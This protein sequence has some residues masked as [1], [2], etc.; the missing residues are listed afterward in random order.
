MDGGHNASRGL[1]AG[2][3]AAP[4]TD[5]LDG[6]FVVVP[7]YNEA[8]VIH[9]VV[10]ALCETFPNVIVVNDGSADSTLAVLAT[11]PVTVISH[12]I[13]LGQGA[14]L[15]TGITYALSRGAQYIITFDGD[16]Q[17][18]VED[19]I[20]ALRE[21]RTGRCDA[22]CGS[23]FL[24][25]ATN[26]P[27]LRKYLLKAAVRFSN[28]ATKTQLTDAHNG[29]RAFSRKAASAI[30]ITQDGMAH[31]SEITATLARK[32]LVIHE[33]PVEVRYTQYSRAKGQ[34]SLNSVNI[35]VEL[36]IERFLR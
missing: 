5:S 23:R 14:A 15:Q 12:A 9:S 8:A 19:A 7:A 11:A 34:S 35:L 17:H 20:A 32:G 25:A 24:G 36:I 30:D 26:I 18:R 4:D 31:A 27:R 33:V 1:D 3:P 22:V 29:L 2:G 13:N 16:G 10:A 6:V 21:V 28:L